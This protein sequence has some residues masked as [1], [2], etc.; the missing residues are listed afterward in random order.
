M[1][2]FE[3]RMAG[4]RAAARHPRIRVS[5]IE[6]RLGTVF[7]AETLRRLRSAYPR[8]RF[9]WLMGADNLAQIGRWRDWSRIFHSLPIAVL[10]RPTYSLRATQ[11]VAA[12]RF[13][14][15][16]RAERAGRRLSGLGAPAWVFLH[17]RLHPASA[18]ALRS[19][20]ATK[21]GG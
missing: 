6:A 3:E 10:A 18:T 5:D 1:A 2:G 13:R 7:T 9:V 17:V 16:R 15:Y 4:A 8:A 20:P 14:R 19:H 21:Q 12:R 11:S